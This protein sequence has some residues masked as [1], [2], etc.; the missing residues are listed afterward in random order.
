MTDAEREAIADLPAE[1]R[2]AVATALGPFAPHTE[3]RLAR[4]VVNLALELERKDQE[5]FELQREDR[6]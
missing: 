5:I 3:Q 6:T 2:A 1:T 4:A